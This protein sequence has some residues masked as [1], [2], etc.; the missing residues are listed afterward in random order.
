MK[1]VKNAW[2]VVLAG[3]WNPRIFTTEWLARCIFENEPNITVEYPVVQGQPYR[4]GARAVKLIA[5]PTYVILSPQNL[6]DDTLRETERQARAV[7]EALQHTPLEGVGTNY[8][9]VEPEPTADI[10]R[11]FELGDAADLAT[12]AVATDRMEITRIYNL[13]EITVS[14]KLSLYDGNVFADF[15]FH[16]NVADGAHAAKALENRV[17]ANRD[18][19]LGLLTAVYDLDLIAEGAER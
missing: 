9:F 5:S 16:R 11:L 18:H 17:L 19:A 8:R 14:F 7:L 3:A 12:A 6:S 13:E 1:P 10:L 4:F 15:N 2:S